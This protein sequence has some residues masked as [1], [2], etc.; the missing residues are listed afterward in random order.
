[1]SGEVQVGDVQPRVAAVPGIDAFPA[2]VDDVT[3]HP[4]NIAGYHNLLQSGPRHSR[5]HQEA[6]LDNS[7]KIAIG[8]GMLWNSWPHSSTIEDEVAS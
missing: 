8:G 1:M 3:Q 5:L 6:V 4:R 2:D 7:G